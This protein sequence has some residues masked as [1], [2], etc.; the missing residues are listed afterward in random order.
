MAKKNLQA[1]KIGYISEIM[2]LMTFAKITD[3]NRSLQKFNMAESF[4]KWHIHLFK[5]MHPILRKT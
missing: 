5:T 1:F 3:F 2:R 4:D